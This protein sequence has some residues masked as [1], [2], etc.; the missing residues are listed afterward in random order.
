MGWSPS[1]SPASAAPDKEH[2]I[3]GK[4]HDLFVNL[5]LSLRLS[6]KENWNSVGVCLR[7]KVSSDWIRQP[8]TFVRFNSELCDTV[9]AAEYLNI[10]EIS[11]YRDRSELFSKRVFRLKL[12]YDFVCS[13]KARVTLHSFDL[14]HYFSAISELSPACLSNFRHFRGFSFKIQREEYSPNP[15]YS[16]IM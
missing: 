2:P 5:D 6:N 13:L 4:L 10:W 12:F 11:V 16:P 15:S 1:I 7:H 9:Y 3:Y 8:Q 14:Q